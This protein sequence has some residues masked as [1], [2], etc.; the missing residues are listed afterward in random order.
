MKESF[1]HCRFPCLTFAFGA[2]LFHQSPRRNFFTSAKSAPAES[3]EI[4]TLHY[5]LLCHLSSCFQ[6]VI[7]CPLTPLNQGGINCNINSQMCA[8]KLLPFKKQSYSQSEYLSRLRAN[9]HSLL[10]CSYSYSNLT[11]P[12]LLS[13][14]RN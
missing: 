4:A 12:A 8:I 5:L 7:F 14:I 13:I 1:C 6:I 3:T 9:T 2:C 10:S 11:K